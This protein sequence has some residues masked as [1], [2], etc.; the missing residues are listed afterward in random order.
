MTD[1][2]SAERI[3]AAVVNIEQYVVGRKSAARFLDVSPRKF[4]EL[5]S[6][7]DF[8]APIKLP[9]YPKWRACDIRKWIDS[10]ALEAA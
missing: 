1:P 8:P 7:P 9:G 5:R 4:D 3:D 6:A 10:R 2:I